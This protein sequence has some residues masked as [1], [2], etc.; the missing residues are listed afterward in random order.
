MR[1][2]EENQFFDDLNDLYENDADFV[3]E[4]DR[5]A[6]LAEGLDRKAVTALHDEAVGLVRQWDVR[7]H[8]SD[9]RSPGT[10][11]GQMKAN[12]APPQ[13]DET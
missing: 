8:R 12:E 5:I 4:A 2:M 6:A 9:S 10:R 13:T 3:A 7:R 1:Y 11:A